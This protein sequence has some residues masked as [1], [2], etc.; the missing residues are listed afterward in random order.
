MINGKNITTDNKNNQNEYHNDIK[1]ISDIIKLNIGIKIDKDDPIIASY[2]VINETNKKFL[3]ILEPKLDS[4]LKKYTYSSDKIIKYFDESNNNISLYL[5]SNLEK[6][7]YS[8]SKKYDDITN[9]TISSI[10][11]YGKKVDSLWYEFYSIHMTIIST[12]ENNIYLN[13]EKSIKKIYDNF[14]HIVVYKLSRIFAI[15]AIIF[16]CFYGL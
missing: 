11:D 9:I 5:G 8:I 6:K 12:I 1:Y 15:L 2:I 4:F 7:V 14:R 16:A 13:N 10:K 3:N